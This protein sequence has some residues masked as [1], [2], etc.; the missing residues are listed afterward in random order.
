[1]RKGLAARLA[2]ARRNAGLTQGAVA[3]HLDTDRVVVSTWERGTRP[4]DET[5][6]QLSELYGVSLAHLLGLD[7]SQSVARDT[8]KASVDYYRGLVAAAERDCAHLFGFLRDTRLAMAA[9]T[10]LAPPTI[11][12]DAEDAVFSAGDA[13]LDEVVA[14]VQDRRDAAGE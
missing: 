6:E 8:P 4:R 14:E 12:F 9:G 10:E 3:Q 2:A 7:E 1:M 13:Q 5:L 11:T